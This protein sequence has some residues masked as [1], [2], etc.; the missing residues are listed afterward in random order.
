MTQIIVTIIVAVLGSQSLSLIVQR[1]LGRLDKSDPVRGGI[2]ILLFM[3]LELLYRQTLER[4]FCSIADK[5]T[6]EDIYMNY[7]ALGGNGVGTEMITHI[8][9][10]EIESDVK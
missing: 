9:E 10:A 3:R 5:R 7:H 1:L 4:G 2:R 8:R 6:A